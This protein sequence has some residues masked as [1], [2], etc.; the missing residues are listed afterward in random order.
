M[1]L[2]EQLRAKHKT[3]IYHSYEFAKE[4]GDN[5]LRFHFSIDEHHFY[6]QWTWEFDTPDE[7]DITLIDELAFSLGMAELVSYWKC[8]CCPEVEVRCGKLSEW[9]KNWWKKLYYN[10]LGEFFYRNGITPDP[11]SFMNITTP[12]AVESRA[13]Y[14]RKTELSGILVPVGGGKDSVVSLELL[15]KHGADIHPYIINPRGATLGC[16]EAAGI[17]PEKTVGVR[18]TIDK[19]LLDLNK[20]G[21]LNGHQACRP[22]RGRRYDLL[23][24]LL[25]RLLRGAYRK[26]TRSRI[27]RRVDLSYEGTA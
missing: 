23:L 27:S 11:D 24:L 16:V 22:L 20:L 4:D 15:K 19:T 10:G 26:N 7:L 9:Q 6:P 12:A 8:A 17:A 25:R 13:Y 3:F 14:G 5:I 2:Y 18:R 21:Y 1:S